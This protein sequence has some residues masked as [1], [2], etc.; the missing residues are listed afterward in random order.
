MI[1]LIGFDPMYGFSNSFSIH[2]A[3]AIEAVENRL[4]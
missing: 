4:R 2:S 1:L 3:F